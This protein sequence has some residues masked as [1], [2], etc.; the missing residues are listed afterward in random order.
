[1]LRH[2]SVALAGRAGARLAAKFAIPASRSTLLRLLRATPPA[3]PGGAPQVLGVDDFA[4]RRGQVY[5]TVLVDMDTHQPVDVL[6]DRTAHTLAA[7]L[8]AHPGAQVVCRDRAG[9]YADG[10]RIG[11]PDAIQV[12]DRFHLWMNLG[13]AVLNTVIAH[14]RHL[15]EP[16]P[17]TPDPPPPPAMPAKP[18]SDTEIQL[19]TRTR[20]RYTAVQQLLAD[21]CSRAE[22]SRRL[23]LDI[24]TVRRFANATCIEDLLAGTR[25]DSVLD[26]F[27]PYLQQR[28]HDGHTDTTTLLEE[29]RQ[30][31]YHGSVQTLRRYLRPSRPQKPLKPP[32]PPKPRQVTKWIMM[33]PA[34]LNPDDHASFAAICSRST[35][36]AAVREHVDRFAHMIR[37]LGGADLPQWIANVQADDLPS[38]H[39]FT[40]GLQRDLEAV[41]AGLTLPHSSG[42]VEGAVNRII[43]WNQ[44]VSMP[45]GGFPMSA[46]RASRQAVFLSRQR[47]WKL[48]NRWCSGGDSSSDQV[49]RTQLY[50]ARQPSLRSNRRLPLSLPPRECSQVAKPCSCSHAVALATSAGSGRRPLGSWSEVAAASMAAA[51]SAS[52]RVKLPS[53][54]GRLTATSRVMPSGNRSVNIGSQLWMSLRSSSA[55]RSRSRAWLASALTCTGHGPMLRVLLSCHS[56]SASTPTIMHRCRVGRGVRRWVEAGRSGATVC[57]VRRVAGSVSGRLGWRRWRGVAGDGRRRR[58]R[59]RPR[60]VRRR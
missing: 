2:I 39:T 58:G 24:Q 14:R 26:P 46:G 35:T 9:A 30:R 44:R 56:R 3:P 28:Y 8:R 40:K 41:T 18:D 22:V 43:L 57:R 54:S 4:L 32:A 47:R 51:A 45:C 37:T 11:A 12:A 16:D 34:K 10:I 50:R 29:I 19:V 17:I 36:L 59:C 42:A 55:S 52:M 21:G 20:E 31:G 23:G 60:R 49:P 27:K 48:V 6:P 33:D 53:S 15:A 38:L 13:E 1:M 25:R 7:W 5:A